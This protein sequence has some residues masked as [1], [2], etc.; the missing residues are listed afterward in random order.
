VNLKQYYDIH[1][2]MTI[3]MNMKQYYE[4]KLVAKFMEK[5]GVNLMQCY[6]L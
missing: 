5:E 3:C 1:I 2:Y 6:D 4:T